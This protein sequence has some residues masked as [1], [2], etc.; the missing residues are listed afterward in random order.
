MFDFSIITPSL[1]QGRFIKDNIESVTKQIG[2]DL[3]HIV[4]D[5]LSS[6]ETLNVLADHQSCH[7][8]SWASEADNGQADAINKGLRRSKGAILGYLNADDYLYSSDVLSRVKMIME[9][10]GT[11][12]LYGDVLVVD[13]SGTPKRIIAGSPFIFSELIKR[14]FIPQP[15]TYFR[16]SVVEK[17]GFFRERLK[18]TMDLEYWLRCASHD[19]KFHYEPQILACFRDHDDSKTRSQTKALIDEGYNVVR[20]EYF[21]DRPMALW[22]YCNLAKLKIALK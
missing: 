22:M 13:V 7:R 3:E 6:D 15:A 20:R 11:D 2:V 17:I 12:V 4:V 18:Y 16:A 1:N 5:G 10:T 9:S 21:P 8:F 14:N 19:L